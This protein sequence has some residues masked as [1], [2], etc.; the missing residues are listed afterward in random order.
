MTV[1]DDLPVLE[2]LFGIDLKTG[3]LIVAAVS[4]V[5]PMAYGCSLFMR[6]SYLLVTIW[7]LVA[8]FFAASIVLLCG[9][10]KGDALLCAIWIWYTLIFVA[11]MLTLTI[12]L[13]LVFTF[14]KQRNRVFIVIIGILW[15]LL[16][17]YFILVVNSYRRSIGTTKYINELFLQ[18]EI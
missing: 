12:L 17:I 8:L 6:M 1:L 14:R 3:S 16:T 18:K 11:V 7:I 9:I 10:L 4:I 2:S 15:Y 5:H 13:A